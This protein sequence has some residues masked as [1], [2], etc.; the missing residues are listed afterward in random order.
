MFVA[1]WLLDFAVVR[2]DWCS[3]ARE[4]CF[5]EWLSALSGWAAALAAGVTIFVL[6]DQI[7]E[8][9]KQTAYAIGEANPDFLI[10]RSYDISRCILKVVNYSRHNVVVDTVKVDTPEGITLAG[11]FIDG[12]YYLG[13]VPRFLVKGNRGQPSETFARDLHL[14]FEQASGDQQIDPMVQ[15]LSLIVEYRVIGQRHEARTAKA[16]ALP[17]TTYRLHADTF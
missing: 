1:M 3:G 10:E 6:S 13:D 16:H 5:R 17:R 15:E 11:F 12:S 2:A 14:V 8:Q 7:K 9:R 4:Y